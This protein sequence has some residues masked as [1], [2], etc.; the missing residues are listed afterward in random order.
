MYALCIALYG[1]DH[2]SLMYLVAGHHS[3]HLQLLSSLDKAKYNLRRADIKIE[4]LGYFKAIYQG[5]R[6]AVQV[7]AT[8]STSRIS[9]VANPTHRS[10]G[11]R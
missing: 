7:C 9:S 1:L 8:G 5:R 2:H 10:W 6:E 11:R 4:L 3:A